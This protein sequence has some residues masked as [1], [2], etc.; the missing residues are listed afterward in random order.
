[1]YQVTIGS[2]YTLDGQE[3]TRWT[4]FGQAFDKGQ[5]LTIRL[6][7]TIIV[8]PGESVWL[9]C[10]KEIKDASEKNASEKEQKSIS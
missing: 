6:D 9:N 1:M 5:N 4:K 7:H 2:K 10:F 8:P 3:K